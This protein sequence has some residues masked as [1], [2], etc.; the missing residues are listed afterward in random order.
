[1]IMGI[2]GWGISLFY[3]LAQTGLLADVRSIVELGSQD[4]YATGYESLI[5]ATI[6]ATGRQIPDA[7]RLSEATVGSARTF[8]ELLGWSYVAIDTDERH[9]AIALDLNFDSVPTEQRGVFDLVTNF[10]TTEH[11]FNQLNAFTVIHDLVRPGG[12]ML[13]CLPFQGS[14]FI[15]HC[16]FT[17]QTD[18]YISLGR[19]NGY[20]LLGLWAIPDPWKAVLIPWNGQ[21]A[22]MLAFP[23][24]KHTLV[25]PLFRK[26]HSHAFQIPYQSMYEGANTEAN[27][28]RYFYVIDGELVNG[29]TLR[30]ATAPKLPSFADL[31]FGTLSSIYATEFTRRIRR[32]LKQLLIRG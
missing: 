21:A 6:K 11:V 2:G 30:R 1:M 19:S 10:G 4:M 22:S 20:E 12:L 3:Q 17:Y 26:P 32:R 13:H 18:F 24:A 7:Q 29:A 31:P 27:A 14:D 9:G 28:A 25:V 23:N 5:G 15:D 8:Y 16:F